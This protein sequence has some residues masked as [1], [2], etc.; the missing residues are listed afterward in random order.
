MLLLPTM[1]LLDDGLSHEVANPIVVLVAVDDIYQ[2]LEVAPL[3]TTRD[4]H[5]WKNFLPGAWGLGRRHQ[6]NLSCAFGL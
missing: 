1:D 5:L 3:N 4:R 2:I 6:S